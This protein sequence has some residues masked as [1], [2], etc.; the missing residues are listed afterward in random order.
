MLHSWLDVAVVRVDVIVRCVVV[1]TVVVRSRSGDPRQHVAVLAPDFPA[2]PHQD[3]AG[4]PSEGRAGRCRAFAC[5]VAAALPGEG[6]HEV[7]RRVCG[8]HLV[9]RPLV[10][11]V[12]GPG[13]RWCRCSLRSG[14]LDGVAESRDES[15][16]PL[17]RAVRA[18]GTTVIRDVFR[19]PGDVVLETA[20][21]GVRCLPRSLSLE[22]ME[23]DCVECHD[24]GISGRASGSGQW[25]SIQ[26]PRRTIAWPS[27]CRMD[28]VFG[29]RYGTIGCGFAMARSS[30]RRASAAANS[31][32]RL[33]ITGC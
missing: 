31:A 13:R 29:V 18:L 1:D 9:G 20:G 32:S 11:R 28:E 25:S 24:V 26:V 15:S 27:R 23:V 3:V 16:Q 6:F 14:A 33:C 5:P 8:G 19:I 17:A 30:C 10:L 12:S 7:Q 4:A 2:Q 21:P 22:E